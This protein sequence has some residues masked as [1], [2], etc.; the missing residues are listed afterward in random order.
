MAGRSA[1]D[2]RASM[3]LSFRLGPIPVRIHAWFLV[4]SVL[5][6]LGAQ[7]GLL[8]VLIWAVGFVVSAMVHELG[9][10][11]VLRRFGAPA[12]V[13]LSLLRPAVGT[14][15]ASLPALKRAVVALAGPAAS[16]ALGGAAL[17]VL[18]ASPPSSAVV[19]AGLQY[20]AWINLVW[21]L[22]NLLPVFPLDG[23][24]V[25][26]AALDR[27]AHRTRSEGNQIVHWLSVA[28]AAV[29]GVV[30]LWARLPIPALLCASVALQNARSLRTRDQANREATLGV[31]LRAAFD[32]LER[33]DVAV[34]VRHCRTVL[35]ESLDPAIRRDAVRL[36][37]YAYA[38]GDDWGSLLELL[39]AGGVLALDAGDLD[40]Y[41]LAARELGRPREAER[42]A[43][44]RGDFA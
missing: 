32:A 37:A 20:L 28:F 7:G 42:I 34:A 9:H 41:L 15:A 14:R 31:H 27:A 5:L 19:R 16:L 8:G 33:G 36:L 40:R 6:A 29:A 1:P 17:A 25:L 30:A 2:S 3:S 22:L 38:T 18:H 12:E 23:G 24:H 11:L 44:L 10:A 35:G 43:V 21:G 39:E 13:H 4:A 26:A